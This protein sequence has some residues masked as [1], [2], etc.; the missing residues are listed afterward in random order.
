MATSPFL[1]ELF[2]IWEFKPK[3]IQA[4]TRY[5]VYSPLH[6]L[7]WTALN[8]TNWITISFIMGIAWFHLHYLTKAYNNTIKDR[9]I[10][11]A[12]V[13]YEYDNRV[14]VVASSFEKASLPLLLFSL[15]SLDL[16]PSRKTP[17]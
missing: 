8:P 9:A 13:L 3:L 15:Y 10:I 12:E 16:T 6:A 5:S 11:H 1:R 2:Y 7:L 4:T 14:C 17:V